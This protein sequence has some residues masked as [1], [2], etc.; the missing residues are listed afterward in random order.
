MGCSQKDIL[1]SPPPIAEIQIIEGP[2]QFTLDGS[3]S[4]DKSGRPLTYRWTASSDKISIIS[5]NASKTSFSIP[6]VS[7]SFT[8]DI[9]LQVS[10]GVSTT[11]ATQTVLIP[12]SNQLQL[13]G[14]GQQLNGGVSNNTSYEWYFDQMNSGTYSLVNCGP[15]SVTMAIKWTDQSFTKTPE[16]ARQAYRSNGGWWYTND[17]INYLGDYSVNN[18]TITLTD[19]NLLK[20]KIDKGDIVILC[21]DMYYVDAASSNTLH[22]NKFYAANTVGWGHFIVIKGYKEV[23][24]QTFF[25]A[26]DPY[27]FGRTYTDY[28]LKGK[29]RYYKASN[30]DA[31]T[32]HWWN[33]AIVVT[34][35]GLSG[36]REAA[37][38]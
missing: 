18:Y 6:A 33:Y 36:G 19:I 20:D 28:S 21:L 12:V 32:N 1:I 30:L 35:P 34:K 11:A 37:D 5:P 27:S 9:S 25:E 8:T 7:E 14:L 22:V 4:S 15:T 31:A 10:N 2:S 16:N 29:D 17:I 3:L 38:P 13:Y 23:D 24:S 26:Y